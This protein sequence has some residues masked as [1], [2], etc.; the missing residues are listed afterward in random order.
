MMKSNF[1]NCFSVYFGELGT[2][3][4]YTVQ[5][6]VPLSTNGILTEKKQKNFLWIAAVLCIALYET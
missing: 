5:V 3:L 4:I 2:L 1:I 6:T